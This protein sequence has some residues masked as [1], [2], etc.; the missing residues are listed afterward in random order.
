MNLPSGCGKGAVLDAQV[1][2]DP[3]GRYWVFVIR[4]SPDKSKVPPERVP[5]EDEEAIEVFWI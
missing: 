3:Q 2:V 5:P 1:V 4:D